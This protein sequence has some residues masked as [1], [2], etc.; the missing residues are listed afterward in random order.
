MCELGLLASADGSRALDSAS[1]ATARKVR[2]TSGSPTTLGAVGVS[3]RKPPPRSAAATPPRPPRTR[4][5]WPRTCASASCVC[6]T[7]FRRRRG[8]RGLRGHARGRLPRYRPGRGRCR[9]FA[10]LVDEREE[11]AFFV[12]LYNA[13][14]VHVTVARAPRS[15]PRLDR[16]SYFDR[17]AY[18]VGGGGHLRRHQA[19]VAR[20]R[21]APPRA[22]LGK[23]VS[24]GPFAAAATPRARS[25]PARALRAG[26]AKSCPPIRLYDARTR[27]AARRRRRGA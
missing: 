4:A 8:V 27:R 15:R 13:L 7:S 25:P 9:R 6:T 17:H 11:P 20:H 26:C 12:N 5:R 3:S 18:D 24:R 10:Q 23:P 21:R 22:L 16:L 19:A 1:S 2:F 14:V